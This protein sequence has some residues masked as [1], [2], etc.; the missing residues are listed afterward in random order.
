[1]PPS[2]KSG[3]SEVGQ[4]LPKRDVRVRSVYPSLPDQA[5]DHRQGS[6]HPCGF[7]RF[8]VS[9]ESAGETPAKQMVRFPPTVDVMESWC[10]S[11]LPVIL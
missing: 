1:M 5:L 11:A 3:T 7:L 6:K 9:P 10:C 4:S 2:P 8:D